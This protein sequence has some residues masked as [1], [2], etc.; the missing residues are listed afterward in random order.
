MSM[1]LS[2]L[3]AWTLRCSDCRPVIYCCFAKHKRQSCYAAFSGAEVLLL[4]VV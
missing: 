1:G 2:F 3:L 4:V